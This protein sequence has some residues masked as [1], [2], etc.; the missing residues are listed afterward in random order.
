MTDLL[1]PRTRSFI[2]FTLDD[3]ALAVGVR[4]FLPALPESATTLV[5]PRLTA[6][7]IQQRPASPEPATYGRPAVR[8]RRYRGD[9]RMSWR[10]RLAELVAGG[11][12]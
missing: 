8:P 4:P 1:T 11:A 6:A 7:D 10:R 5:L 2:P 12:R 9:H 3:A